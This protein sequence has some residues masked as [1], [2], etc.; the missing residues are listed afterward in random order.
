MVSDML[1]VLEY[2]PLLHNVRSAAA[3]ACPLTGV[4]NASIY[5]HCSCTQRRCVVAVVIAAKLRLKDLEQPPPDPAL[6]DVRLETMGV[7]R[8]AQ[9][10]ALRVNVVARGR[11]GIGACAFRRMRGALVARFALALLAL[12]APLAHG[13]A[14]EGRHV[15]PS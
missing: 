6:L 7:W 5:A 8:D 1:A 9:H 11:F 2:M 4:N 14:A 3:A 15:L 12:L 13:P 10:P